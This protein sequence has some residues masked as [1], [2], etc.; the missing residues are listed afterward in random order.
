MRSFRAF[1]TQY[2]VHFFVPG[3]AA[4]KGSYVP[5]VSRSTGRAFLKH[6]AGKKLESWRSRLRSCASE[7][8][9]EGKLLVGAVSVQSRIFLPRPKNHYRTGKNSH[10]LKKSAP[11]FPKTKKGD[12]DKLARAIMDE[13]SRT[14]YVDDGQV[15]DIDF[16]KRF[17][18]KEEDVGASIFVSSMEPELENE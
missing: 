9:G 4:G 18:E 14:V 10:L 16:K 15:A 1:R 12:V 5:V 2:S 17:A 6:S 3:L 13:L 11:K 7:A 8:W